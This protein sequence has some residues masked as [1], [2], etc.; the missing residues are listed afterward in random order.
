MR[1][2]FSFRIAVA[3]P[4]TRRAVKNPPNSRV[5]SNAGWAARSPRSDTQ[6][7]TQRQDLVEIGDARKPGQKCGDIRRS[8]SKQQ[9]QG[10][11]PPRHSGAGEQPRNA[12]FAFIRHRTT[13]AGPLQTRAPRHAWYTAGEGAGIMSR[14]PGASAKPRKENPT[15]QRRTRARAAS[16]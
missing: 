13:A 1:Q 2:F 16:R 15:R 6:G 9:A 7:A 14:F 5:R 11:G 4:D 8:E 10:H 3:A 12:A